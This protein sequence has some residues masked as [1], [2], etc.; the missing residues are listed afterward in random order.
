MKEILETSKVQITPQTVSPQAGSETF[1][2]D[3]YAPEAVARRNRLAASIST[4]RTEEIE[5][6]LVI[7]QQMVARL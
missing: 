7:I 4:E 6:D 3:P 5:K 1:K 2:Y